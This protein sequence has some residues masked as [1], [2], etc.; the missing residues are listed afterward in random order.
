MN[1]FSYS[2]SY[3][4][5]PERGDTTGSLTWPLE[6]ETA[7]EYYVWGRVLA[8]DPEHDSFHVLLRRN[9]AQW[10]GQCMAHASRSAVDLAAP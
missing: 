4:F 2:Q 1:R 7:G 5:C 8:P 9:E 6:V 3:S 10:L